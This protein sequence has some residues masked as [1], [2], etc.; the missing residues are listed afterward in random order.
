MDRIVRLGIESV[1]LVGVARVVKLPRRWLAEYGLEIGRP[2]YTA[3]ALDDCIRVHL[4]P[5]TWTTQVKV[6]RISGAAHVTLLKEYVEALGLKIG[7]K[8]WVDVDLDSGVL[9]LRRAV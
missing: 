2:L 8:M 5:K 7:D 6:R 4:T 9:L 1:K 3:L